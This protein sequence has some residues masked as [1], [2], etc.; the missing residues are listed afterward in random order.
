M[1]A[2]IVVWFER[3]S[4]GLDLELAM[5]ESSP[6]LEGRC[7]FIYSQPVDAQRVLSGIDPKRRIAWDPGSPPE[8]A[9]EVVSWLRSFPRRP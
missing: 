3:D 6:L 2:L 8:L 5:I 4:A 1:A 9:S 7:L